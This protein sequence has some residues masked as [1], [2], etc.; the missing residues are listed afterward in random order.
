[1]RHLNINLWYLSITLA[2]QMESGLILLAP[3]GKLI[4]QGEFVLIFLFCRSDLYPAPRPLAAIKKQ[5]ESEM[6]VQLGVE[7]A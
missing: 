5:D 6:N 3:S 4:C 7:K 1:M 2:W